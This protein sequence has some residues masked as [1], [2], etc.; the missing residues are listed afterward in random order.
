MPWSASRRRLISATGERAAQHEFLEERAGHLHR[1]ARQRVQLFGGVMRFVVAELGHLAQ[2]LL[3]HHR[4]VHR[5][6]QRIQRLVGADI[7][8][9]FLAADM[10]LARAQA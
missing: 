9:G 7:A 1:V 6:G 4:Q 3:A 10:L 2:A 5:G 8:G